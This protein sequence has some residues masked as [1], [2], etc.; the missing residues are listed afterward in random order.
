MKATEY[1]LKTKDGRHIRKATK[2]TFLDGYE[3]KF[4]ERMTKREAMKQAA[5]IRGKA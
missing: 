1:T 3:V 5:E 2:V 4:I